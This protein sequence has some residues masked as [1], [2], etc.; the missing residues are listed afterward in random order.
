MGR[1]YWKFFLFFFFAQLSTVL[2]VSLAIGLVHDKQERERRLINTAPPAQTMVLAAASTLKVA[3]VESLKLLLQGW[4][5]EPMPKLYAVN[6][7]GIDLLKRDLPK[8]VNKDTLPALVNDAKNKA[9]KQI[10]ADDGHRYWLFVAPHNKRATGGGL[11]DKRP[12]KHLALGLSPQEFKRLIP[13]MPLV[14]GIFVSLLFAAILAWYFS[15]PI[16]QLRLAFESAASGNLDARVGLAMQGRRDELADLGSA[17]D[18]MAA[19]VSQLIQSQ[20]HLMHQVS[21]ELRSPLARLQIAIGLIKQQSAHLNMASQMSEKITVSL[22]RI[23][24]ESMRMDNLVGELLTLSR[25]ESGMMALQKEP[26]D[27][28]ELLQELVAD[29]N[30]EGLAHNVKVDFTATSV[31]LVEAQA[32]LL[33]RAIDNIIRNAVKYSPA[34]ATVTLT[35]VVNQADKNV[36]V[37]V[38][39]KGIGIKEAELGDIFKPFYRA[40]SNNTTPVQGYGLGLA[41]TKQIIE[42]HTGTITATNTTDAGLK[43][44]IMLPII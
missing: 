19:R 7:E 32:D 44:T 11:F 3:G 22:N 16:K 41:I 2:V 36:L 29:A 18:S 6:E 35:T 39:D 8:G 1:L 20:T 26:V 34:N 24:T 33:Q 25:L 37:C 21:H 13:I 9:I 17:F 43:I 23:E 42:A 5:A 30:F 28:S 12:P 14:V 4:A 27:L 38:I 31:I 10:Q 15:K 40:N